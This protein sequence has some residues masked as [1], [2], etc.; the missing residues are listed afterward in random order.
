MPDKP[1]TVEEYL[2]TLPPEARQVVEEVRRSIRAA[3]PGAEERIRYDMP[4][5]M[6][7]ERYA[8]HYA[9]WKKHVGLYPVSPLPEAL[10][11]EVAPYRSKKDSVTF[12]YG[13]PVPYDLIERIAAELGR[14]RAP[15]PSS[16]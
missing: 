4:A 9:G 6:L 1:T 5:V 15:L 14:L 11:A 13:K 2:A 16:A 8:L 3:L 7:S 10:E 12:P